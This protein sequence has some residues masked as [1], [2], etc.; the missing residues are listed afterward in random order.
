MYLL[1]GELPAP[2]FV[3]T[4][5]LLFALAPLPAAIDWLA[6]SAG[7]R[8]SS[9]P[10]RLVT[11]AFLGLAFADALALLVTENWLLFAGAVLVFGVYVAALLATLKVTGAWRRVIE[12]HFST[13]SP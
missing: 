2:L 3:P 9:N 11:G 13:A 4:T 12:E 6:Q 8:E 5:Q 1:R 7:W 10:I